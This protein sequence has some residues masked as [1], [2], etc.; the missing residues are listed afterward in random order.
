MRK[1]DMDELLSAFLEPVAE[2][3]VEVVFDCFFTSPCSGDLGDGGIQK[4]MDSDR[5]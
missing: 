4:L 5:K 1:I 3:F 2:L